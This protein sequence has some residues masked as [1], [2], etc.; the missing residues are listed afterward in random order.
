MSLD[1]NQH[2]RILVV[3]D[4]P[5]VRAGIRGILNGIV[6]LEIVAEAANGKQALE[7]AA[8]HNPDVILMDLRMPESDGV[9]AISALFADNSRSRVLVLT[10]YDTDADILRAIEA[11]ATG[12]ILK[13]APPDEL[14]RAIRATANGQSWLSPTVASRLMKRIRSPISNALTERE[15]EVI[16]H[17]ARGLSNK[18]I[19]ASLAVSE[20]TIKSHLIH[21]FHKLE[22]ADRTSAVIAALELGYIELSSQS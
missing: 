16:R 18:E 20:A 13:D 17:V 5:V 1:S 19:A 15:H 14:S 21:I 12:Y 9:S 8:L 3:D 2:I 6:G 22:V 7:S 4:H 10:T 11:G